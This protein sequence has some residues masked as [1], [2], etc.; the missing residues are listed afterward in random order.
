MGGA[1]RM[2]SEITHSWSGNWVTNALWADFWLNEGT[3]QYS[4]HGHRLGMSPW[5]LDR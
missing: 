5:H 2:R 3:V 1:C 4:T